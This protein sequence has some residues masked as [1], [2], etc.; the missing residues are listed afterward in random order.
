MKIL[1]SSTFL[2]DRSIVEILNIAKEIG[3]D[4]IEVWADHFYRQCDNPSSICKTAEEL[5]LKLTLHAPSYDLNPLSSNEGIAKESKK[6]IFDA[7]ILSEDIGAKL[8][9]IHPGHFS[10]SQDTKEI[11]FP[12]LIE[13]A[14]EV[15]DFSKD[16]DVQI[17][18]EMMEKRP[19]EFFQ[20]PNDAKILME[21]NIDGIGLTVD[22]A[23]LFT[24]GDVKEMLK[25]LD[26]EWIKHIHISDSG[27]GK[28]HLPLGEGEVDLIGALKLLSKDYDGF[29]TIEAAI[30]GRGEELIKKNF[31]YVKNLLKEIK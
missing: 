12:K 17:T 15:S 30:L 7:I 24:I 5:D 11:F 31:K 9:V 13:F 8:I 14:K 3:Y 6:Q 18:F 2:R 26:Y 16:V 1:F 25:S 29:L 22:I 23:H 20:S 21:E 28:T 10:S 19:K 27:Y 4:G